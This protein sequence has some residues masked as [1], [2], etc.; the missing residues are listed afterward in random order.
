MRSRLLLGCIALLGVTA[1][2][3]A[4]VD[5]NS[6]GLVFQV[7]T[8]IVALVAASLGFARRRFVL[9]WLTLSKAVRNRLAAVFRTSEREVD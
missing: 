1:P 6:G 5:P 8:P 2:A 4:Y 9:T 3:Y 7:I